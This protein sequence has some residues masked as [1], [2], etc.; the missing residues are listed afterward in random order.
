LLELL[1]SANRGDPA[2][3]AAQFVL[4]KRPTMGPCKQFLLAGILA[5]LA[6][7]L[8]LPAS[9]RGDEIRWLTDEAAAWK[10]AAEKRRPVL[11]DVYKVPCPPCNYLDTVVYRDPAVIKII[12]DNFIAL[13]INGEINQVRINDGSPI[14]RFPTLMYL[15][16]DKQLLETQVGALDSA[17]LLEQAKRVLSAMPGPAPQKS[18]TQPA[19]RDEIPTQEVRGTPFQLGVWIGPGTVRLGVWSRHVTPPTGH[20][21]SV[22]PLNAHDARKMQ[23]RETLG[24]AVDS[25]RK[26]QWLTCLDLSRSITALYPDLAESSEAR[27][28]EQSI[29]ME[30]IE[31]LEKELMENLGQVYWEL[32]QA[33]L[34]HNGTAQAAAYMEKIV[35]SCPG[36]RH[37]QAAQEF[38]RNLNGERGLRNEQLGSKTSSDFD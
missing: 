18:G 32:G 26:Q 25:Y 28:L 34:R 29:G 24:Q 22:Q 21:F 23:A 9:A 38:L 20:D 2:Q 12:N 17:P 7:L 16:P 19:L 10:E 11:L 27:Q 37:F 3:A 30:R 6:M 35:Q 15:S 5:N 36:T 33:K 31:K 1:H 4:R 8:P 14:G 13:K